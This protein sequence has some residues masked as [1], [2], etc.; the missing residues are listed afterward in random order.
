[1][2]DEAEIEA[3]RERVVDIVT[4]DSVDSDSVGWQKLEAVEVALDW[5][6]EDVDGSDR[7][8]G[9]IEHVEDV[10]EQAAE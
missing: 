7:L 6:L 8:E 2:K 1:M 5:V 10:V 4:S 3:M 9:A